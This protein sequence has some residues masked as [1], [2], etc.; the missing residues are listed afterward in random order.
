MTADPSG[1]LM[2]KPD[3]WRPTSRTL[4]EKVPEVSVKQARATDAVFSLQELIRGGILNRTFTVPV[5][6]KQGQ[7]NRRSSSD[8]DEA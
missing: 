2:G 4:F 3:K 1:D 7:F 5:I 6:E 8:G